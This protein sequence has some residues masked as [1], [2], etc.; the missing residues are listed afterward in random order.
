MSQ[1]PRGTRIML[2]GLVAA[3][4]FHYGN[5]GPKFQKTER[6]SFL[7]LRLLLAKAFGV[8]PTRMRRLRFAREPNRGQCWGPNVERRAA[9]DQMRIR[10][11]DAEG[12]GIKAL[13]WE[14]SIAPDRPGRMS[15]RC[16]IS[17]GSDLR[18]PGFGEVDQR[19]KLIIDITGEDC[20]NRRS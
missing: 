18:F 7:H 17:P 15:N 5:G 8:S 4:S 19:L 12:A 6:R 9:R 10:R 16:G 1:A 3:L 13:R 2:Q 20:D 11:K 14:K